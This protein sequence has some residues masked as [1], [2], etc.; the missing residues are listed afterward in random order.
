MRVF[1]CGQAAAQLTRSRTTGPLRNSYSASVSGGEANMPPTITKAGRFLAAACIGIQLFATA[2]S[3]QKLRTIGGEQ[4]VEIDTGG[5]LGLLPHVASLVSMTATGARNG[6]AGGAGALTLGIR[7]GSPQFLANLQA[8][9]QNRIK[10]QQRPYGL[11]GALTGFLTI[12]VPSGETVRRLTRA[13]SISIGRE[14]AV[15]FTLES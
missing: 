8:E 2:G 13:M 11:P 6:G 5:E 15:S 1:G 3:A 9:N 10:L 14:E 12:Q 7:V 4:V